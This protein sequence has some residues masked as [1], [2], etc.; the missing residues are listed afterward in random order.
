MSII[1]NIVQLEK[2]VSIYELRKTYDDSVEFITTT[3]SFPMV[4]AI[5]YEGKLNKAITAKIIPKGIKQRVDKLVQNYGDKLKRK[6]FVAKD[7]LITRL[8]S[9]EKMEKGGPGSG[10]HPEGKSSINLEAL[11][12]RANFIADNPNKVTREEYARTTMD[13]HN[14]DPESP[15][16]SVNIFGDRANPMVEGDWHWNQLLTEHDNRTKDVA[17]G[18]PGSGCN[19]DSGT[20]GRPSKGGRIKLNAKNNDELKLEASKLSQKNPNKKI[21]AYT[22]FG[23]AHAS[24]LDRIS[25]ETPGNTHLGGYWENGSFKPFSQKETNTY[26]N[27]TISSP[28]DTEKFEKADETVREETTEDK[29]KK[30][31]IIET[32]LAGLAISLG[33]TALNVYKQ[34]YLLGKERGVSISGEDFTRIISEEDNQKLLNLVNNNQ[35]YLNNFMQDLNENYTKAI[36][37]EY[38]SKEAEEHALAN[39]MTS[40]E[41]RLGLYALAALGALGLGFTT[42]IKE[43]NDQL[44]EDEDEV[45]GLIWV[46]NHDDLVCDGC[47]DNDGK[48]FTFEE[49]DEEYQN[50]ECLVRCRC[51]ET[52]VPTTAPAE[53]FGKS[54]KYSKL[55]KGGEGSGSWDG[56]GS[57]RFAWTPLAISNEKD[58]IV[59]H[60]WNSKSP[61]IDSSNSSEVGGLTITAEHLGVLNNKDISEPKNYKVIKELEVIKTS[62]G[63]IPMDGSPDITITSSPSVNEEK[64]RTDFNNALN[65]Y[66]PHL[67]KIVTL[68]TN[69]IRDVE[70]S[71]Q[72]IGGIYVPTQKMNTPRARTIEINRNFKPTFKADK[73]MILTHEIAHAIDF[74]I[75]EKTGI[76]FSESSV[77]IDTMKE[78]TPISRYSMKNPH[79]N[80]A[81]HVTAY[82]YFPE[83]LKEV[84]SSAFGVIDNLFKNKIEGLDLKK[85]DTSTNTD[86][87]VISD[88][89]KGSLVEVLSK[90]FREK[91]EKGK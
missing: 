11:K 56:P 72:S 3:D 81:E 58:S 32:I 68:S 15:V 79:E 64:I 51:A 28:T 47:A 76:V 2:C 63:T 44:P 57:P 90:L 62:S 42:G 6:W 54:L 4:T 22:V 36:S 80:F 53:H 26:H 48:F 82:L 18:G 66:P 31:K 91:E 49:F 7:E 60:I 65:N 20:C 84:N 55:Q 17:K 34:A 29:E 59:E 19:P 33:A 71:S 30:K 67:Q 27:W 39:V 86:L 23:D 87:F 77:W 5:R 88:D 75:K 24:V 50:N 35:E 38:T 89:F 43:S 1:T 74:G 25:D 78:G 37:N 16:N 40:A 10:R 9:V 83:K 12:Q 41:S 45:T 52:S 21:I 61:F 70:G 73:G 46:T 13:W 69:E 8:T 14:N 85:S